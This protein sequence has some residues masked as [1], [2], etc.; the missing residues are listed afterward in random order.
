VGVNTTPEFDDS[1]TDIEL[2]YGEDMTYNLPDYSDADNL[3]FL[4]A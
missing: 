3:D 2:N 4:T 1:F